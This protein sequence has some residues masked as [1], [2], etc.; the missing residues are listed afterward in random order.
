MLE[1]LKSEGATLPAIMI[2]GHGD[3]ETAVRA[4]RA[5]AIDYMGKPV[6]HERLLSAIDRALELDSG[7]ADSLAAGL[8][9]LLDD[10]PRRL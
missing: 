7:S 2:S 8:R 3:I 5:G 10:E 1:K 9:S 6:F 4:M